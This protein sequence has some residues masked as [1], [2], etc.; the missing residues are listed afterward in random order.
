MTTNDYTRQELLAETARNNPNKEARL[1][2]L[3]K[4]SDE[5]ILKEFAKD[6][7]YL[8]ARIIAIGKITDERFLAKIAKNDS[9]G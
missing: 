5:A 7:P 2:A 1:A 6:D 9:N 3:E 8:Q 4:I